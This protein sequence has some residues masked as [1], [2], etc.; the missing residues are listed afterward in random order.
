[1]RRSW[2][3]VVVVRLVLGASLVRRGDADVDVDVD[4]DV[5]DLVLLSHVP[6]RVAVTPR[7]LSVE[8]EETGVEIFSPATSLFGT[9]LGLAR[10]L[11]HI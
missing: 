8:E 3:A 10:P 7:V 6:L 9:T 11:P 4:A 1:M 5:V 2:K